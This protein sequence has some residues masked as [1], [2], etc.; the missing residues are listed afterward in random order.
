MSGRLPIS[1]GIATFRRAGMRRLGTFVPILSV[2]EIQAMDR[3]Q[4]NDVERKQ[5]SPGYFLTVLRS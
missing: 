4:A 2:I 1:V 3:S 5:H